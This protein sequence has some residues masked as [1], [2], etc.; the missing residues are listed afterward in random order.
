MSTSADRAV[1]FLNERTDLGI[2]LRD[3]SSSWLQRFIGVL[4]FL[5]T[6]GSYMHRFW[7]TIG[8]T[9]YAPSRRNSFDWSVLFHEAMHVRQHRRHPILHS[10]TYLCPQLIAIPA[11]GIMLLAFGLAWW[12]LLGL[13]FIL[14]F[15]AYWRMRSEL[16]GY[17]MSVAA[18]EL[19]RSGL[20]WE[21]ID[22]IRGNFTGPAYWF[23]WPFGASI[24]RELKAHL[25]EIGN[26]YSYS[27]LTG[28]DT[29]MYGC[30]LSF[31]A[32][33]GLLRRDMMSQYGLLRD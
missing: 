31:M 2:Q 5:P 13:L 10:L 6:G 24:E 14:P 22:H 4:L 11:F 26:C 12:S 9:V 8:R 7:T 20:G 17:K 28:V 15:P 25:T 21:A 16:E 30:L 27:A 1:Q 23:M 33:E 3:K 19:H 32:S 18:Y 29:Y